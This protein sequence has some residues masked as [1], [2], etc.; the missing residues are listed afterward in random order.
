M[1]FGDLKIKNEIT[2]RKLSQRDIILD[3]SGYFIIKIDQINK[4]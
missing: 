2:D 1:T 4:K 3:F